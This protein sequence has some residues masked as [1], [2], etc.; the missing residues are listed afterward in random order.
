M[1]KSKGICKI[2]G[3]QFN[4]SLLPSGR[5]SKSSFCSKECENKNNDKYKTVKTKVCRYCGKEFEVQR[6]NNG[7]N[8][9][10]INYCSNQCNQ[11]ALAEK[12]KK[13]CTYCGKE[14]IPK[15]VP[16]GHFGRSS[17]CSIECQRKYNDE[18][19]RKS[20]ICA[21]CGKEFIPNRDSNNNI[22]GMQKYCS[23]LCRKA[24]EEENR[25]TIKCKFCGKDFK[26]PRLNNGKISRTRYCSEDCRVKD[27]DANKLKE[28]ICLYCGKK[29]RP[30]RLNNGK[31]SQSNYCSDVCW[32]NGYQRNYI[33][34]CKEKYGVDYACMLQ[35]AQEKQGQII[36]KINKDFAKKLE[37][38]GISCELETI[39]LDNYSYDIYV[40]DKNLLIEI[41]PSYTHTTAGNHYNNFKYSEKF[42]N[43]QLN[44]TLTAQKYGYSCIHIF[45]WDDKDKILNLLKPKVN[46][47]VA[48]VKEITQ[49][50]AKDFIGKYSLCVTDRM[51]QDIKYCLGLFSYLT[52]DL[53]EIAVLNDNNE[54]SFYRCFDYFVDNDIEILIKSV[55]NNYKY[56][57][58]K[59]IKDLSKDFNDYTKY[60]FTLKSVIEPQKIWS[61]TKEYIV[62]DNNYNTK[63]L[64]SQ[65]WLPV[66]NCGYEKYELMLGA[67]NAN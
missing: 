43:Y 16:S 53:I 34:S 64:L 48:V 17:Y 18:H 40:K 29:F 35:E 26:P 54:L 39:R 14:F 10:T 9:S 7:K 59:I 65:G 58:L 4:Q 15:K 36:S 32:Y 60:G 46:I 30:K 61:K 49:E 45:D 24:K 52:D 19:N 28:K 50:K 62:D 38:A 13:V 66:Y 1:D 31:L 2:C 27:Y 63:Q 8:F 20:K 44:K 47:G 6:T 41:D 21:Y 51:K 3:K 55:V 67:N 11:A 25:Q 5:Y 23:D 57:N 56:L 33:A 37:D 12:H 42:I 22:S